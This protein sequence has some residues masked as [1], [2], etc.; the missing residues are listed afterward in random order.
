[1]GIFRKK[2]IVIYGCLYEDEQDLELAYK[3][4]RECNKNAEKNNQKVVAIFFD[5]LWEDKVKKQKAADKIKEFCKINYP[6]VKR[7]SVGD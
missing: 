7:V 4:I 3:Q 5:I 1:M 2:R 6:S